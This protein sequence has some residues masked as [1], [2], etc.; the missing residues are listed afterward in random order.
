MQCPNCGEDG[1]RFL[2]DAYVIYD[3]VNEDGTCTAGSPRVQ[4]FD[5][6]RFLECHDCG[7]TLEKRDVTLGDVAL[8]GALDA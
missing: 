5:K 4:T 1:V 7:W 8:A 3:A 2:V 6:D